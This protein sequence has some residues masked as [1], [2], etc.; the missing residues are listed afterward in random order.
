MRA[1]VCVS[2]CES[3]CVCVRLELGDALGRHRAE[4]G[5]PPLPGLPL[6]VPIPADA[7]VS[8]LVA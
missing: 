3:V 5:S 7:G 6:L 1:C 8:K 2:V 4:R